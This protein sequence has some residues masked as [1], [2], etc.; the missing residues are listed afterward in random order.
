MNAPISTPRYTAACRVDNP[1]NRRRR[2]GWI[3]RSATA[4]L[5]FW[6]AGIAVLT[7]PAAETPLPDPAPPFADELPVTTALCLWSDNARLISDRWRRTSLYQVYAADVM[8]PFWD[9]LRQNKDGVLA[10]EQ[11]GIGWDEL[12]EVC[13]GPWLLAYD[14]SEGSSGTLL[15]ADVS[16]QEVAAG[17]LLDQVKRRWQERGLR[18]QTKPDRGSTVEVGM[19][20]DQ[21]VRFGFVAGTR[22]CLTDRW[23]LAEH[24][25]AAHRGG[26]QAN[27]ASSDMYKTL[28][29]AN[30]PAPRESLRFYVDP[31]R[32]A[33]DASSAAAKDAERVEFFRRH[34]FQAVGAI[35]GHVLFD[36][37]GDDARY[38]ARIW[39]EFPFTD[40]A[41][42]LSFL[43]STDF[44]LPALVPPDAAGVTCFHW[45]LPAALKA[46]GF[47]YDDVYGEQYEGA[48]DDLLFVL[49]EDSEGPQVDLRAEVINLLSKKVIRAYVYGGR[50]TQGNPSGRRAMWMAKS[51]S[52]KT[53][54]EAV[55]RFFRGDPDVA[56]MSVNGVVIWHSRSNLPLLGGDPE[57]PL[58]YP[59]DAVCVMQ[60]HLVLATDRGLLEQLA[61]RAGGG[62]PS[63][64]N[65]EWKDAAPEPCIARSWRDLAAAAAVAHEL[66]KQNRLDSPNSWEQWLLR[67]LLM[68]KTEQG[69]KAAVDG[70]HLPPF[71]AIKAYF[72]S[73]LIAVTVDRLGWHVQGRWARPTPGTA[74]PKPSPQAATEGTPTRQE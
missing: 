46:Y 35:T 45:N 18:L 55:T 41:G 74:T 51:S 33:Q 47:V 16:G 67:S 43:Q 68:T 10:S 69:W 4:G 36:A 60:D 9:E 21:G 57:D 72:G 29:A 24:V 59:L 15:L 8:R 23:E 64:G 65:P 17:Q 7:A 20:G 6:A 42:L 32:L 5:A 61:E 22:L 3:V 49:A 13:N 12:V 50:K 27:L 2:R 28:S 19:A 56:S 52:P 1:I 58:S 38:Q 25:L 30:T 31:W 34:G 14:F 71:S 40:A 37:G 48:F 53:T 54:A 70:R 39:V 44:Q 26:R 63:F 11:L 73:E 66:V 62:T